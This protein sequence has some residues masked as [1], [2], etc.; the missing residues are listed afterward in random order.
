MQ[1]PRYVRYSI[2]LGAG[3]MALALG[4]VGGTVRAWAGES[5]SPKIRESA[6]SVSLHADKSLGN[7]IRTDDRYG[8]D[9]LFQGPRGWVYWNF[10]ERPKPIQN[11]N[12]WPDMQSTYFIGRFAMP[13]GSTMTLHG[14]FPYVAIFPVRAL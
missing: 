1:A 7:V 4:D 12:L 14:R 11:P 10:L 3:L 9:G 8:H 13:P 2:V 6:R 5:S